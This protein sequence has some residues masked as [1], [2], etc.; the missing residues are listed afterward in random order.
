M[1]TDGI[2]SKEEKL[3]NKKKTRG[4]K[5]ARYY[6]G[7]RFPLPVLIRLFE[8]RKR[9]NGRLRN[10]EL[11]LSKP[12]RDKTG[13]IMSRYGHFSGV[14][15]ADDEIRRFRPHR[16]DVGAE[17][18]MDSRERRD[19]ANRCVTHSELRFDVDLN[20]YDYDDARRCGCKESKMICMDCWTLAR[21]AME[22]LRE[23]LGE[24][25][26]YK[27]LLWVFSGR[28]G[29][30]CWVGDRG[31]GLLS[32]SARG[33][34]L[35]SLSYASVQGSS[36]QGSTDALLRKWWGVWGGRK[37]AT[38][39]TM[40]KV[41]WPRLD[42]AVTADPKHLI[43]APFSLHPDTGRICIAFDDPATFDPRE[44]PDYQGYEKGDQKAWLRRAHRVFKS[45]VEAVERENE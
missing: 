5:I 18:V 34:L 20:D 36:A 44:V 15:G 6:L 24:I 32:R 38:P 40:S 30:H 11:A 13:M 10:R 19:A 45:Y 42:R 22:I 31:T 9:D 2:L 26:G 23:L 37:N 17:Y 29:V 25:Y 12:S 14:A 41:L 43:K 3:A 27:T 39:A 28:R 1:I 7:T 4:Y 35:D 8:R 16:L 33:S 21:A